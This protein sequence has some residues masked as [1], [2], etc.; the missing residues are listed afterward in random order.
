M[1]S[2][3]FNRELTRRRLAGL[4]SFNSSLWNSSIFFA[5]R[6]F[7]SFGALIFIMRLS[8]FSPWSNPLLLSMSPHLST[9]WR[10][11]SAIFSP[12][13]SEALSDAFSIITL[14]NHSMRLLWRLSFLL[15]ISSF[16]NQSRF[17]SMATRSLTT[18]PVMLS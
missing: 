11:T 4:V 13:I 3:V 6:F 2:A 5:L 15:L 12:M 18:S 17:G 1:D 9:F 8:T 10:L 14:V 16:R 7:C